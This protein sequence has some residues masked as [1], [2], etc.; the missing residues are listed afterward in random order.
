MLFLSP[1]QMSA[2]ASY[3][4]RNWGNSG[5]CIEKIESPTHRISLFRVV[6]GDGSR[7]TLVADKW[8]NVRDLD[9]HSGDDGLAGLVSE[10]HAKASPNG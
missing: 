4:E 10:M 2:A 1:D 8:G 9:T 6:A 3:L 5:Y 7:F